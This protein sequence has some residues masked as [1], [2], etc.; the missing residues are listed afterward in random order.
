MVSLN[1]MINGAWIEGEQLSTPGPKF[2]EQLANL[3]IELHTMWGMD[4]YLKNVL[5]R[6]EWI[7]NDM[8]DAVYA[9]E[10]VDDFTENAILEFH[11]IKHEL[12]K[13][14]PIHGDLW[15]QNI[16]VDE[17]GNL[18]GIIDWDKKSFG[19]PHWDFRMIRR[20]VGWDGLDE[21]LF[22]YNCSTGFNCK[23]EYIEV[24]DKI[25]LCH[26]VRI[27]KERGL[28][29]H[30]KPDAIELFENY[31]KLWPIGSPPVNASTSPS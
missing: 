5:Y 25:S 4:E 8:H 27:R 7:L 24:L 15:R 1:E 31:K 17:S 2:I 23:R 14:V 16:R 28:L 22:L 26:S 29:R 11:E 6:K 9:L 10:P 3:M 30:D 18:N 20:W 21:L 19:D 13:Y 12:N